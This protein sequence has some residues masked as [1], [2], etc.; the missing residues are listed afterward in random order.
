MAETTPFDGEAEAERRIAAEAEAQTGFLD[1]TQ[2]GLRRLPDSLFRLTHLRRLHLGRR[3]TRGREEWLLDRDFEGPANEIAA[4]LACLGALPELEALSILGVTCK[5]L[6]FVTALPG[7]HWLD[8]SHTHV[9]DLG[10]LSGLTALQSLDCSF[11][12]VSDLGPLSGLTALQSLHCSNTPVSDLGPLSGL[13]ALQSLTCSQAQVSDLGPLSGLTAL[14]SLSCSNTHVSDLGPLSGLTALQLLTCSGTHVLDLGPLS[15]LT[16]LQS[17]ICSHTQVSDLGP[18][19]SLTALQFLMCWGTQVSDLGPLSGLTELRWL[20]CW[21]THVSDLSPLSGLT[22]LQ[23]LD[24]SK[25]Q[26]S[27]LGPLSSLTALQSLECSNTHVSHLG[28]L[29]SLTALHN[30]ILCGCRLSSLFTTLWQAPSLQNVV[31]YQTSLPAVPP[32]VLSQH[33]GDN[34]LPRLRA[35]L[36]EREMSGSSPINEVKLLILGNGHAGKTQLARRLRGAAFD[37]A[38]PSTHGIRVTD[39]LLRGAEGQDDTPL[40]IWDFGG[41]DI[42]HGAHALFVRSRSVFLLVWSEDTRPEQKPHETIDGLRFDNQPLAYW[43][44]YVRHV[45][46]GRSP[47]VIAQTKR[48]L[49]GERD[50]PIDRALLDGLAF[51]REVHASAAEPDGL[52]ELQAALR[53]AVAALRRSQ[54][55]TEIPASWDRLRQWI[56]GQRNPDGTWPADCRTIDL[57]TFAARRREAGVEAPEHALAYLHNAGVVFHRPGLFA[58]HIVLDQQWALDAVYAVFDR[59]RAVPVLRELGGRFTRP[60][61]ERLIWRDYPPEDQLQFLDMMQSCGI[62]FVHSSDRND[63]DRTRYIV[64]DLLP[65]RAEVETD[66]VQRWDTGTPIVTHTFRYPFL[67]RG[68]M[69][70]LMAAL[71]E[72][73]GLAG[74]YW[75]GGM[76]LYDAAT[77]ARAILDETI[78]EGWHGTIRLQAR[79]QAAETLLARLAELVRQKNQALGL[80]PEEGAP[81]DP[82]FRQK[83]A[84][85]RE[86]KAETAAPADLVRPAVEP[87]ARRSYAVSYA[88][89]DADGTGPDREEP[90]RALETEALR[91]GI[92]LLRDRTHMRFGDSIDAFMRRL[93]Q[94][95]RVVVILSGKYLRSTYCMA[96]LYR[97]WRR[98][99]E[100]ADF[101][102]Q[103]RAFGIGDEQIGD[104]KDRAEHAEYWNQRA[105]EMLGYAGKNQLAPE[106]YERMQEIR[107]W[108]NELPRILYWVKDTLRPKRVDDLSRYVFGDDLPGG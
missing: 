102:R 33:N 32:E 71:G 97:L 108:A 22:T 11:T 63:P 39:A 45:G 93:T 103:V 51:R 88:W 94:A 73:A 40:A 16:A 1:L 105:D 5:S 31:L 58:D 6:D 13:A 70:A 107:S 61:L 81:A 17:L 92:E 9:T 77:G 20:D 24:C 50:P 74:T 100:R 76:Y 4:E 80:T 96:E 14:Q 101:A 90:V 52:D 34:C 35:W 59:T 27:D 66:L 57:T 7:L 106:D 41:Q 43:V 79:G 64:P 62:C 48:D 69:R 25:T 28:P 49:D 3:L 10:P 65:E 95:E 46:D 15:G 60:L 47:V 75:R 29:S 8:Y 86:A 87:A 67:H 68:V 78:T 56:A 38:E 19:S 89:N 36:R 21:N 23:S 42:Y 72:R 104:Y 2:L 12:P 82:V 37:P 91:H 55:Q 18:L 84:G 83:P 98:C 30:L 99:Q 44:D 54:D 85:G 53:Q 26:V